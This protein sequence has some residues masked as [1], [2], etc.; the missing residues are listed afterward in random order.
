MTVKLKLCPFCSSSYAY[1][2]HSKAPKHIPGIEFHFVKCPK[3][4]AQTQEFFMEYSAIASWN[5]RASL[6]EKFKRWF[7]DE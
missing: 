2:V 5:R 4:G 7:L 3:C 1:I 6:W